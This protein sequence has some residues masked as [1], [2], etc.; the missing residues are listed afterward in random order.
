M[1]PKGM[2]GGGSRGRKIRALMAVALVGL[3]ITATIA[4]STSGAPSAGRGP[5]DDLRSGER[6]E[7][8]LTD[9]PSRWFRSDQS[10]IA[11]TQSLVVVGPDAEAT[12]TGRSRTVHTVTSLIFPT[13]AASMP[14]DTKA[15]KG[16][17][18][19]VLRDPG[20]YVFSCKI[21][22]YMFGAVI[23]DD[24]TTTG[25]DL[26][27]SITLVHGVT[28]P[29]SSDLATRLLRTFFIATNP[30]N[31]MDMR[32]GRPWHVAYPDVDVIITGGTVMNLRAVLEAAP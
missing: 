18:S 2:E 14:F 9:E 31:W 17:V 26:G 21:H 13:G 4:A 32:S 22:P 20:L 27:E 5:R 23:V 7:F 11:G 3:T 29:T 24:P 16:S 15:M 1:F 12:F 6:V 19:V 30:A 25:L 8:A 28:V 10:P